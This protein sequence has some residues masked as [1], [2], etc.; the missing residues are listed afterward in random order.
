MIDYL[1]PLIAALVETGIP[2]MEHMI[3][4]W[5]RRNI[6][7]KSLDPSTVKTN[8]ALDWRHAFLYLAAQNFELG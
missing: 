3:I 7:G 1:Y 5:N 4:S 2:N 6:E 8:Q